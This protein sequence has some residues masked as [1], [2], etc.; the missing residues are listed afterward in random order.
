MDPTLRWTRL[1]WIAGVLLLVASLIGATQV[2][3]RPGETPPAAKV[4]PASP[5]A[6]APVYC[7]GRVDV[8]PGY[9]GLMPL[10]SGAVVSVACHDGQ[11]V[12]EGD[13]LLQVDPKPYELEV[14]KARAAV[15]IAQAK[16]DDAR[17]GLEVYTK[18][19]KAQEEQIRLAKEQVNYAREWYERADQQLKSGVRLGPTERDV[20]QLRIQVT[21]S[22]ARVAAEEAKLETLRAS[23]PA[24][25]IK[26]AE[27]QVAYQTRLV[28][29][30]KEAL[31]RCTLKAPRVGTVLR[32]MATVGSQYGPQS[33][34]PA[35]EF[36]PDGPLV[37][38][39]DL[40]QEYASG[41]KLNAVAKIQDETEPS[42][43]WTGKVAAIAGA[44]LAPRSA[45]ALDPASAASTGRTLEVI[46]LIDGGANPPKINQRMRATITP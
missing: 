22:E 16:L 25:K 18:N 5:G 46:V 1:P 30:A 40:D 21:L 20:N 36:A 7:Q 29:Q 17:Q 3:N 32:V 4:P 24:P 10:Q 23:H 14:N 38:R 27:E 44:Y 43:V 11:R 45:N 12:N 33:H 15:Q 2:M 8:T 41:V 6:A 13:P 19:L 31:G 26:E 39:I 42:L 34:Q 9:V 37:V 35:V 28:D